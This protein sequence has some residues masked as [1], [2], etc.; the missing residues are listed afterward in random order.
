MRWTPPCTCSPA[1]PDPARQNMVVFLTDGLPT[2]GET[3]DAKITA[4]SRALS[5]P[6]GVRLF[7][8]G[9]GYDVDV[10]FLRP[11]GRSQQRRLGLR[12]ARRGH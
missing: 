1:T 12:A 7:D 9:V 5:R 10:H 3:D 6:R 11:P 4:A 2:V 8:F